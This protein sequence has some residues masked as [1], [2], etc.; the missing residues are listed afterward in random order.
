VAPQVAPEVPTTPA[1]D[2]K[3]IRGAITMGDFDRNQGRYDEAIKDYS[4]GLKL[5]PKNPDLLRGIE[6]ARKAKEAEDKVLLH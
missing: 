3:K 2:P 1:V 5:D 6:K 4:E